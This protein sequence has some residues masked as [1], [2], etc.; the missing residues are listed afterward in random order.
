MKLQLNLAT[1]PL[2][3]NRPLIFSAAVVGVL[4]LAALAVLSVE[5]YTSLRDTR[6]RRDDFSRLQRE[7]RDFHRERREL[8]EF[9]RHP[10]TRRL[11]DRAAF[12]NG[13]IEQRGF[14]WTQVFQDLERRLPNGVRVISI[15][16]RMEAGRVQVK[17]I[18][19]AASDERKIEFLDILVRAPEFSRVQVLGE[20]RHGG[21]S[22]QPDRVVLELVAWYGAD[23]S[24]GRR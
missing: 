7:I 10:D 22:N 4:G 20:T 14:A 5:T 15:A 23:S 21:P 18:V 16:P 24:Q 19:G 11:M 1:A 2:E 9:F 3:N 12:L 6:E 8:E 13:L 17:L